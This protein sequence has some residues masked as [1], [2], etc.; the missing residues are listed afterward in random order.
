MWQR[1][2]AANRGQ[3][4]T[5]ISRD[6]EV[7]GDILFSGSL[8]IEGRVRGSIAARQG[9]PACVRI[10]ESGVVAGDVRAPQVIVNGSVEGDIHA[11]Q[12]VVLAS[13]ARVDGD[14]H[15]ASVEMAKGARLNGNLVYAAARPSLQAVAE[16]QQN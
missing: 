7:V 5:L 1:N 9:Q 13:Q 12:Q 3:G 6:T 10:L 2:K 8:E 16:A 15:Y 4:T 11:D 14:V